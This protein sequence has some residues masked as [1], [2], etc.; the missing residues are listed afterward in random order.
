MNKTKVVFQVRPYSFVMGFL[1]PKLIKKNFFLKIKGKLL[2][3]QP[4]VV[5]SFE[6]LF[7][8]LNF[9]LYISQYPFKN[10]KPNQIK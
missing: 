8:T 10:K 5:A 7:Q 6:I 4:L 3:I 2:F 9:H 1:V